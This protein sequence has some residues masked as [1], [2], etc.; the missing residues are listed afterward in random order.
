MGKFAKLVNTE[1]KIVQFKNRYGIP[2][3]VHIRYV[4]YDDLALLQYEDL[5]LPIV[6]IVEGGVRIPMHTF[7]LRFLTHFR[8]SPLQCAPNVFRIVMGTAVLME[9]LGLN[10]TVHDITYVYSLQAT[11]R[12]QYT[13]FARNVDRKLV[14][15][16]PDSSKGR[17]EDF[18]VFTGNW[19]NPHINCPLR[20]G[21][22]DRKRLRSCGLGGIRRTSSK[23]VPVTVRRGVQVPQLVPPLSNPDFVPSLESSETGLPIIRFPSIFDPD[24]KPT[25]E[26]P[27]QKRTVNIAD[28]LRTSAPETSRTSPS[29]SPLPPP[30]GFSQ[31][32]GVMRKKRK[33][34]TEQDDDGCGQEGSSPPQPSK[35]KSPKKA[36]SKNDRA[37]QKATGQIP[38]GRMRQD[39]LKQPWSCSFLLENRSVDEGDS[40]LKSGRGVRGGQV[41]EAVGKALLLPEDMKV[42][43]EKRSK[44]ML[45]NLKRDSILAVQGIFEAG[46]RLL[47]TERRLNRS[48]EEIKRLKDLE[49]SASLQ[50]KLDSEHKSASQVRIENSQ[51]KDALTEAEAKVVKAEQ[52]AQAYY[53]QGWHKALDNAGVDDDSELYDLAYTRQPYE[54]PVPEEGNELEAGEGA[55]GDP[56]VPGSHEALSEPALADDPKVTEDRPDDQIHTAESQEGGEGSDVDETIRCGRL[57]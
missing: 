19:Q 14:T 27:I 3:D 26:M 25:E 18:L 44:H 57:I 53:D 21:V 34:G 41:A 10:L 13:L 7:L 5:V 9:K 43:Q 28:V 1:E 55:T 38:Q 20:P 22:P 33:R 11:G 40:V 15:G 56:T 6:A 16:L 23:A 47:E 32:E 36:K 35:A 51:L 31:G 42:W 46:N 45:E 39:D 50:R 17:D 52:E 48:A 49:S 54:D 12:D 24:P 29:A 4:P 2:E 37:L 30:P 8:L